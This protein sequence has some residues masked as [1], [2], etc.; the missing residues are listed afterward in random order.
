MVQWSGLLTFTA[1][2]VGSIPGQGTKIPQ[3]AWCGTAPPP[4]INLFSRMSGRENL[5]EKGERTGLSF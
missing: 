4:K 1:N 2:G 5:N 3:A